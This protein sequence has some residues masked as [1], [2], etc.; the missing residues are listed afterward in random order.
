MRTGCQDPASRISTL[1]YLYPSS[2]QTYSAEKKQN[3]CDKTSNATDNRAPEDTLGCI[4]TCILGLFSHVTRSVKTDEDSSCCEVGQ[5]PVPSRWRS[6][7]VVSRH[8]CFF[9][10]SETPCVGSA[11]R[12]PDDVEEE[13]E[14]D[15]RRGEIEHIS[16]KSR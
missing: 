12:K 6:S 4:D 5:T 9:G 10:C 1:I 16:K 15:E 11:D 3:N 14:Q 13:V 8:E 7:S 2:M